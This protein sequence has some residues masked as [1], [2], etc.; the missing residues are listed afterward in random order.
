[1]SWDAR[2]SAL[3]SA[4]G[5]SVLDTVEGSLLSISALPTPSDRGEE[6]DEDDDLTPFI[7]S[8]A[9]ERESSS[10]RRSHLNSPHSLSLSSFF[11]SISSSSFLDHCSPFRV[12]AV[13]LCCSGVF[14]CLGLCWALIFG[15][16]VINPSASVDATLRAIRLWL[17]PAIL[18]RPAMRRRT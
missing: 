15:D 17:Q 8:S 9:T 12:A 7:R 16:G 2:A 14:L 4:D 6:E 10:A 3:L 1:M 18:R 13:L 5:D 11:S